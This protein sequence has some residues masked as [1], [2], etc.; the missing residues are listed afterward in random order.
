MVHLSVPVASTL[1]QQQQQPVQQSLGVQPDAQP[2]DQPRVQPANV[3]V[4][5]PPIIGQVQQPN[6]LPTFVV[7]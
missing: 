2:G 1:A 5:Q 7:S 6:N 3:Q 4:Q